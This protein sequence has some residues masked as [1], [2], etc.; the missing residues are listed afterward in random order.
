MFVTS[1]CAILDIVIS[2]LI[3]QATCGSENVGLRNP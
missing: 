3:R 2:S 1:N